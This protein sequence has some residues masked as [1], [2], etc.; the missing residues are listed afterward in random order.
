MEAP[1][2][3]TQLFAAR[4]SIP[5]H[6]V[7]REFGEQSVALNLQSG[8]YHGLNGVAGR[9]FERLRDAPAVGDVIDPLAAEFSQPR[10][11]IERDLVAFVRQLHA[12]GLIE[13]DAGDD[14]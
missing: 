14:R 10:E 4:P 12:R 9:M 13:L 5:E 6:V 11:V 2:E 1:S 8:Q 7:S 3:D